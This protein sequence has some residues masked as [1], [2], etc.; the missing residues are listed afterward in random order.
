[1]SGDEQSFRCEVGIVRPDGAF[2]PEEIKA[3][4]HGVALKM[5]VTDVHVFGEINVE[6]GR[7]DYG[8]DETLVITLDAEERL[9]FA[10]TEE[11]QTVLSG[12]HPGISFD[13]LEWYDDETGRKVFDGS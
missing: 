8:F 13:G 5:G 9:L 2:T 1:M 7:R 3:I 11:V 12:I 4:K 6:I 10:L